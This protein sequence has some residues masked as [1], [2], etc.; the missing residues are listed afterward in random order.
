MFNRYSI[1]PTLDS[2]RFQAPKR[3]HSMRDEGILKADTFPPICFQS[4][5]GV[6]PAFQTVEDSRMK[7]YIREVPI[8]RSNK[9][10]ESD[11]SEDCL[12]LK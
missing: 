8:F 6:Q 5:T 7:A 12:F 9:A 10:I 4:G 11:Q 2:L 1:A 3:P